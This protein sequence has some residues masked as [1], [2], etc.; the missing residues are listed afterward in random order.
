MEQDS[1]GVKSAAERL[2][3]EIFNHN[4]NG[5][6]HSLLPYLIILPLKY[7]L[8]DDDNDIYA[9]DNGLSSFASYITRLIQIRTFD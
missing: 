3:E 2:A 1:E 8:L 7:L 9:S 5:E 6:S 4:N